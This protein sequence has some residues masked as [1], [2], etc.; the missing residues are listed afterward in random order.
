MREN[1]CWAEGLNEKGQIVAKAYLLVSMSQSPL[2]T[3]T[4]LYW[5][6]CDDNHSGA[7]GCDYSLMDATPTP[8]NASPV[9]ERPTT[10]TAVNPAFR[11]L[12][13]LDRLRARRFPRSAPLGSAVAPTN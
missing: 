11:S 7:E 2:I 6:P 12:G 9:T 8:S 10:A 3:L 4:P 1:S 13:M 5:V